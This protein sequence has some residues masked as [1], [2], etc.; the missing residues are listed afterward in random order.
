MVFGNWKITDNTIE[1]VEQ[2]GNAFVL[3]K[4][5]MLTIKES[6]FGARF[7]EY[8]L[9][10]TDEEWL[11]E[12]DLYDFNYA[13]VY[14]AAKFGLDFNYEIFDAT[15]AEQFEQFEEEDDEDSEWQ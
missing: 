7:Y 9:L 8:I 13:F 12:N 10:A 15:L 11:S 4:D 2:G 14:A 1:W 3:H 6:I 5:D